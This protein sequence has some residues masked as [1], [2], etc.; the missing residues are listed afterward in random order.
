MPVLLKKLVKI[1]WGKIKANTNLLY[2]ENQKLCVLGCVPL[3]Y[4]IGATSDSN[5]LHCE[6]LLKN[7]AHKRK[8]EESSF[9]KKNEQQLRNDITDNMYQP[10]QP[11][12]ERRPDPSFLTTTRVQRSSTPNEVHITICRKRKDQKKKAREKVQN[13]GYLLKLMHS[14]M[15]N[16]RTAVTFKNKNTR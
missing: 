7:I 15:T 4:R 2:S 1:T 3:P 8:K 16:S 14:Q 12:L 5:M 9:E 11:G 13:P 6:P 10:K